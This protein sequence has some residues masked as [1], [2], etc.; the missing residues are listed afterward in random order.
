MSKQR[1]DLRL[2]LL[3]SAPEERWEL[4]VQWYTRGFELQPGQV[5]SYD[6]VTQPLNPEI[7][8]GYDAVVLGGS[9][10]YRVSQSQ[11][12]QLDHLAD[13]VRHCVA[14]GQPL[15]AVCYGAHVLAHALGGAVEYMPHRKELGTYNLHL[16][17]PGREDALFHDMPEIF[18]ANCGRTDDVIQLPVTA[19]PLVNSELVQF[20]AFKVAGKPVYGL[21]FHPEL[22]KESVLKG[23]QV[24][25]EHGTYFD[26]E[27][28]YRVQCAGV[29]ET[30]EAASLL[31]K[32]IDRVVLS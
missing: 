31:K 7:V 19:V 30:P 18:K 27:E 5:V 13:I 2:L 3:Q 1:R 4:Q 20:H 9:V 11:H 17:A 6:A 29:S 23:M 28:E 22:D 14:V 8:D 32:F 16:L 24:A 25:Y 26:S 21:Q 10:L 12:D 15:L